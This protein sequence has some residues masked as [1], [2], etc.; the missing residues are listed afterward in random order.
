MLRWPV[1]RARA[2]LAANTWAPDWLPRWLRHPVASYV[3]PVL[4]IALAA[5]LTS[6]LEHSLT[7]FSFHGMAGF[8]AIL[9]TAIVW[10]AGPGIVGALLN[11]ITLNFVVVLP[12][13]PGDHDVP[14]QIVGFTLALCFGATVSLVGSQAEARRRRLVA[15][16]AAITVL[17]RQESVLAAIVQSSQDAITSRDRE[18]RIISWNPGAERLYGYSAHEIMGQPYTVLVPEHLREQAR[19]VVEDALRDSLQI[20]LETTHRHRDGHLIDVAVSGNVTYDSDHRVIGTAAIVHDITARRQMEAERDRLLESERDARTAAEQALQARD[21][22]LATAAHELKTPLT[23]LRGFTQT[24]LLLSDKGTLDPVRSRTALRSIEVQTNRLTQLVG[25]LFDV[26]RLET[27]RIVLERA[28]IDLTNLCEEVVATLEPYANAHSFA[29]E[30]PGPVVADVD[31]LRIE[32]V[33]TNLLD[34]AI[35]YS[36]DGGQI[37]ISVSSPSTDNAQIAIRDHGLGV[38]EQH[39]AHI[40]ERLTQA[41]AEDYRSGLGLGLYI[42]RQIV[43]LHGGQIC[44]EFPEDGGSLFTVLLPRGTATRVE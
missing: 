11:A 26:A 44:A 19:Q 39:R 6:G 5:A 1:P 4:A 2:W 29:L 25:R 43:E 30:A 7:R 38:D 35:K 21:E 10:G 9:V 13:S 12:Q 36:P 34:N 40:F 28:P 24:L 37:A 33:L 14:S 32:Q 16:H 23:G 27:G 42:S 20:Q 3:A 22:F 18:G 31:E 17:E 15:E 41:H 8:L